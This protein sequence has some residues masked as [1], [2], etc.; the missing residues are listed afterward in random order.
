[1]DLCLD[2]LSPTYKVSN[3]KLLLED[4]CLIS[5]QCAQAFPK[6]LS[7][8]HS[9]LYYLLTTFSHVSISEGT[10]IALYADDTK[11]WREISRYEDHFVLQS[12]IN[13]LYA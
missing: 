3:N 11:I 7:W 12:D 8:G 13:K 6:D 5:C 1:M 4:P 9:C 2:L 10:K